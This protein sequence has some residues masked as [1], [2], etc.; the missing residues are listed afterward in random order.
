MYLCWLRRRRCREKTRQQRSNSL[1]NGALL[2]KK[3]AFAFLL[4]HILCAN[5]RRHSGHDPDRNARYSLSERTTDKCGIRLNASREVE[6]VC[7][8][9]KGVSVSPATC[10]H[11]SNINAEGFKRPYGTSSERY[12]VSAAGIMMTDCGGS[13]D[14]RLFRRLSYSAAV[15]LYVTATGEMRLMDQKRGRG[16]R[17]ADGPSFGLRRK[18]WVRWNGCPHRGTCDAIGRPH[19]DSVAEAMRRE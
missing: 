15:I 17:T 14:R 9:P 16:T 3:E 5:A 1:G 18:G 12:C 8:L 2:Q 13:I 6:K 7:V 10:H 4:R 19:T 11:P